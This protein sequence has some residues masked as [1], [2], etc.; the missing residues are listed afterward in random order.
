LAV[1]LE[2]NFQINPV[3]AAV[4]PLINVVFLVVLFFTL[5]S[6]F[7]LQSGLAITPPPSS[8]VLTPARQPHFVSISASPVPSIYF[9]DRRVSIE[10][11][12]PRL[13]EMRGKD[14]TLVIRADRGT[15]YEVLMS[16]MNTGLQHGFSIVLATARER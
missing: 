10:E 11:L 13:A 15:S 1:K 5:S 2:R 12:G 3:L 7:V 16:V 4:V 6:R 14:R 8:F 9:G